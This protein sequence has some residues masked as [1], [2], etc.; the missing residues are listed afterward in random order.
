LANFDE[1]K[2][3]RDL[4][5]RAF[6]AMIG[7]QGGGGQTDD[8]SFGRRCQHD[9]ARADSALQGVFALIRLGPVERYIKAGY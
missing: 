2:Y 9:S 1:R 3:L 8:V 5:S 7:N 6:R 4:L